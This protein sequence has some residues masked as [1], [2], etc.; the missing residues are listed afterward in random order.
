LVEIRLFGCGKCHPTNIARGGPKSTGSTARER[1]AKDA[2]HALHFLLANAQSV[3]FVIV[4]PGDVDLFV[5]YTTIALLPALERELSLA[6]VARFWKPFTPSSATLRVREG[7][8]HPFW[9]L[10]GLLRKL[11]IFFIV[12]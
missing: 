2:T 3:D 6:Q 8:S 5:E 10:N 12:F 9:V 1:F 4:V 11:I 7:A